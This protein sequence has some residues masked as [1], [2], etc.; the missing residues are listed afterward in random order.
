MAKQL[1]D[2]M[3]LASNEIGDLDLMLVRDVSS[4]EDKKITIGD[5]KYLLLKLMHPIGSLYFNAEDVR[6]PADVFGFGVWVAYAEG[7]AI[8]GKSPTGTFSTAGAN[9]GAETHSLTKEQQANMRVFGLD[10]WNMNTGGSNAG[11]AFNPAGANNGVS[12]VW[13][14]GGGT[15]GQPHNNIQPSIIVYVWRRVS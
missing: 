11:Y 15:T 3:Q 12:E 9:V 5:L 6:N 2:L 7:Y 4:L 14:V 8:V 1:P 13:A 10:K